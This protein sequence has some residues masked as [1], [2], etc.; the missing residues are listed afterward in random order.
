MSERVL[1]IGAGVAG[2]TAGI[3]LAEAGLKVQI[4]EARDRIGGR[5]WTEHPPGL[6]APVELGAEFVHG[7]VPEIWRYCRD[8]EID[9][10]EGEGTRWCTQ[11]N[12]LIHCN[13]FQQVNNVLD[14][15]GKFSNP[16]ISVQDALERLPDVDSRVIERTL[17]YVMG[18]HAADPRKIGVQAIQL[19]SQAEERTEGDRTFRIRQGYDALLRQMKSECEELKV[20][21][22][23]N[24]IVER[25]D[26]RDDSVR[27]STVAPEGPVE[28]LADC[29]IVTLPLGV[30]QLQQGQ[31]GYVEF[32]PPLRDKH[33]ALRKLVLGHVQRVTLVFTEVFWSD[34][35]FI[36]RSD[37][38]DMQF[39]FS[40]DEFFPTWWTYEPLRVPVLTAWSPALKSDRLSGRSPEELA[41]IALNS[42]SRILH[43]NAAE[44]RL[45]LVSAHSHNWIADPFTCG[46]YSY[47]KA[48]GVDGFREL[49]KPLGAKLYFAGEATEFTG[50]HATV[51]G[52]IA[53]GERV[54]REVLTRVRET[55]VH[56][57]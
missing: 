39:L 13:F 41:E 48:A 29:A 17:N 25:V 19:D 4:V 51:H 46:A 49:A 24:H 28:L 45:R 12:K 54:A 10:Y 3:R 23:L 11:D 22:S 27:V 47:A 50:H 57:R 36:G 37:L 8:N 38:S 32:T 52:A 55:S 43:V 35:Q 53:S 2:L 40:D 14:R 42:L 6:Q 30:L 16:D 56:N 18:F 44:L 31:R 5:I 20:Q 1:L 33:D 7:K 21:I 15:I 34:T 26:W 9:F